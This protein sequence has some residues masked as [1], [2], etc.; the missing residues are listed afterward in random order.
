M[1]LAERLGVGADPARVNRAAAG[2]AVTDG[3]GGAAMSA[4]AVPLRRRRDEG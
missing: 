3:L 2:G 1:A 4:M